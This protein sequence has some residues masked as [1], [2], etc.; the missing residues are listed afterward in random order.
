MFSR[1]PRNSWIERER[2]RKVLLAADTSAGPIPAKSCSGDSDSFGPLGK[3]SDSIPNRVPFRIESNTGLTELG[4]G[5]TCISLSGRKKT[6]F[7]SIFLHFFTRFDIESWRC[8]DWFL[9]F[10]IES[11]RSPAKSLKES[12][13]P[14]TI[15]GIVPALAH[16]HSVKDRDYTRGR[17]GG[18]C[19][20]SDWVKTEDETDRS[21]VTERKKREW[22]TVQCGLEREWV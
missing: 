1:T 7:F 13:H 17:S 10:W 18:R 6:V 11:S 4:S 21:S 16:T 20:L 22:E 19:G 8:S 2:E 9:Y 14:F 3:E 15:L 12:I 5:W